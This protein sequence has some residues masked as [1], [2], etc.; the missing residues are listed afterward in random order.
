MCVPIPKNTKKPEADWG[1]LG[2]PLQ[3]HDSRMFCIS[4]MPGRFLD[5]V[6][7]ALEEVPPGSYMSSCTAEGREA[8][9]ERGVVCSPGR[10]G[11]CRPQSRKERGDSVSTSV[12]P[13]VFPWGGVT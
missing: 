6:T 13:G 11:P 9:L 1:I 4:K 7:Q 12:R 2:K 3:G 10:E 8:N 5:R